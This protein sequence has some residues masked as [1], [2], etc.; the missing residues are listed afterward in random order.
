VTPEHDK[1]EAPMSFTIRSWHMG[2]C[3][4]MCVALV[5]MGLLLGCAAPLQEAREIPKQI[6]CRDRNGQIL[7]T[8]PYEEESGNGYLVQVDDHTTDFYRKDQ[9]RKMPA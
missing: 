4:K 5:S 2:E 1:K 8:G 7:Y 9:C 6:Q 3:N